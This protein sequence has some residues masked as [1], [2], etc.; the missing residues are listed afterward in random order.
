MSAVLSGGKSIGL[1]IRLHADNDLVLE[2]ITKFGKDYQLVVHR[3][4]KKSNLRSKP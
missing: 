2:C 4:M 1:P 3:I